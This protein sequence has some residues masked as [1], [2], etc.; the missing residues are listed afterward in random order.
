MYGTGTVWQRYHIS[1]KFNRCK[2]IYN[3]I[4]MRCVEMFIVLGYVKRD[5]RKDIKTFDHHN[6][7]QDCNLKF[8][9][10]IL[11]KYKSN[12]IY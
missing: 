3:E 7:I 10:C 5:S 8:I 12:T 2:Q 1:E 4:K 11:M 6:R 9:V